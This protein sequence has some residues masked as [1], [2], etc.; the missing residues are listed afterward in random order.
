MSR[1]WKV[2]DERERAVVGRDDEQAAARARDHALAFGAHSGIDDR[3]DDGAR[4]PE[5][6]DLSQAV[7]ALPDVEGLDLVRE[8]VDAEVGVHAGR[9]A[10]H[11]GDRPVAR[12]EVG[13]Q[14][15]GALRR[16][17]GR[18]YEHEHARGRTRARDQMC[19]SGGGT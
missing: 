9:D 12:A 7:R 11:G 8:V 15:E 6:R 10:L 13:L 4:G 18:E 3:D 1:P 2:C 17:R 16:E 5:G 14:H 19:G